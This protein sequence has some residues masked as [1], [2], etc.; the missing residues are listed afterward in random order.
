MGKRK[1]TNG[2]DPKQDKADGGHSPSTIFV[3]NLPFS[4]T[5][6][7]LEGAFSEVGPVRRC[8]LVSKKG[9]NE[10]RGFG[11]VQFAATEDAERAIQL[12]N[13]ASVAG[14]KIVV[15]LAMHR[16]PLE[17]RRSKENHAVPTDH[18]EAKDEAGSD[19]KE[20]V[21]SGELKKAKKDVGLKSGVADKGNYSEKQ[22]VARTVVFGGLLNADMAAEVFNR[23]REVDTVCSVTYPLPEEELKLH[24][25]ARDGCKMHA[26]TVL[27]TS[28]KSARACVAALHQQEIKGGHVWARQLGG[29][30]SKP[31]KWRLI[32][33]NL[34]FKV[35]VND[36]RDMFK[37]AGF[38]WDVFIPQTSKEGLSKGL[39]FV[40]F[41]CKHDAENAIQKVNGQIVGKRPVAVDWAVPKKT[42]TTESNSLDAIKDVQ[43]SE[44]K[45]EGDITGD[46]LTN[47]VSYS[48]SDT[49]SED[50][51]TMVNEAIQEV[52]LDEAEIARKVLSNLISSSSKGTPSLGDDSDLVEGD[53]GIKL[54]NAAHSKLHDDLGKSSAVTKP[55]IS[56]K[57]VVTSD[58]SAEKENDL[59]KTIFISNLPFDIDNE[60]VKQRFSVFGEVQSFLPVLHQVTKRPKG[61]AFLKFATAAAADAAVLA[62]NTSQGSGILMKG[63]ALNILKALDKKSVQKIELEKKRNESSDPRNLY[64]AKEGVILEGTPAA[65]G[66]SAYD[67]SKRQALER[68]KMAKLQFPNYHVSRT[69]LIMY[70]L[71]KSTTEKEL[72]KLCRDAVLSRA[73][74]QNPVIQQ[75]KI[76]KDSKKDKAA[77]KNHSRGVAFIEFSEHEHALVALRVLN[78]N[79]ETFGPEHRP[80]VE[81]ALDNV[82]TL[83]L[84]KN[85][86][87]SQLANS[88]RPDNPIIDEQENAASHKAD[89]HPKR[90]YKKTL[91][92]HK[93]S[94]NLPVA[95]EAAEPSKGAKNGE[96]RDR[97]TNAH[98]HSMARSAVKKHKA[99]D[100]KQ[101]ETKSAAKV[102]P[103]QIRKQSDPVVQKGNLANKSKSRSNE[104]LPSPSKKRKLQEGVVL[105]HWK[106]AKRSKKK[107]A[108]SSDKE[109]EDKLDK[110][111]AQ[112]RLKFSQHSSNKTEA[113]KQG[114]K[115]LRRWFES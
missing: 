30:G 37:P 90:K 20:T 97:Q 41:T 56:N 64:L 77:A 54:P 75:I 98:T 10:H 101:G 28:V 61:T 17:L 9:S 96:V 19:K 18:H 79:P 86:L 91:N 60:E 3:T 109:K 1:R 102:E 92:K 112:Y 74:K 23:A 14:R 67:M 70:N 15:K 27:S 69:R 49:E 35:T 12:K 66:V 26:G 51:E 89:D 104:K 2:Q 65:E 114:S 71:P 59:D 32:V 76:L 80:I 87:Q 48:G 42:Y 58:E 83:R 73:C 82:Q 29:E 22:R 115:G 106:D 44:K 105:E 52:E 11:F 4:I 31:R 81:F 38:V 68:K 36:I 108:A 33:R 78:N 84:R 24:G 93:G 45:K 113:I 62:A 13:G 110:L 103:Q 34:P 55:K 6:S 72:K 88:N 95:A 47:G 99:T 85:K 5:T 46:N 21:E 7:E 25:L 40:S 63:R 53:E 8:F 50:R 39:A 57:R 107:T 43:L 94:S 111:I 100:A 16:L